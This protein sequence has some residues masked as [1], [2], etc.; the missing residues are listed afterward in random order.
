MFDEPESFCERFEIHF[1]LEGVSIRFHAREIDRFED[2]PPETLKPAGRVLQGHPGDDAGVDIRGIAEQEPS[3]RPVDD[4]DA[5]LI[6]GTDDEIVVPGFFEHARNFI[7]VMGKIRVH[8]EYEIEFI[9]DRVPEPFD[10]RGSQTH[11]PRPMQ[12][13]DS[14]VV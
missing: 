6:P 9:R 13:M 1:D 2:L 4:P 5:V 11:F 12:S 8:L 3:D 14:W 10:I 7:R